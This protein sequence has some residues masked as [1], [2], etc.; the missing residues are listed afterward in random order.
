MSSVMPEPMAPGPIKTVKMA[1]IPPKS[2]ENTM[3]VM[4]AGPSDELS[5]I[6]YAVDH[7]NRTRLS[8]KMSMINAAIPLN[9]PTIVYKNHMYIL[10]LPSRST[11]LSCYQMLFWKL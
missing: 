1:A 5:M 9:T 8:T 11:S 4:I 6:I 3:N 7:L 2:A 10:S